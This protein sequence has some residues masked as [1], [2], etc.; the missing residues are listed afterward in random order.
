MSASP[1]ANTDAFTSSNRPTR[2]NRVSRRN[3]C[4]W[5][6]ATTYCLQFDNGDS[7]CR[8]VGEPDQWTDKYMGVY[9]HRANDA[10]QP[11]SWSLRT[12]EPSTP[13]IQP[14]DRETC[15]GVYACL[16]ALCPLG[17][18]QRIAFGLTE[19]Q[20]ARYGWLPG[21]VAGQ[22]ALIADLLRTYSREQLRGVPGFREHNRHL[23]IRGAGLMLPTR[24]LDGYIVALDLRRATVKEKQA[25]YFKLSSRTEDDADAPSPGA[26]AHL[27]VPT[28]GVTVG[29]VIGLTEGIKKADAAADALGYPV[30]S[31]PGIDARRDVPTFL[32]RLARN[33]V[34]LML[35]QDD[36][37]KKGGDVVAAVTRARQ[38]VAATAIAHG[39]A[40]RVAT[41]D[42]TVAKG[43]DDL[44]AAG[45]TFALER[46]CPATDEPAA[47]VETPAITPAIVPLFAVMA[48]TLRIQREALQRAGV[49][50][51]GLTRGYESLHRFVLTE[52]FTESEKKMLL[53][54]LRDKFGYTFG[55]PVLPAFATVRITDAEKPRAGLSGNSF[56]TARKRFVTDGLLIASQRPALDGSPTGRSFDV[57]TVNGERL[58]RLIDDL[59]ADPGGQTEE[60][61]ARAVVRA[62][63]ARARHA[64]M[65]KE[66]ER[67]EEQ[68]RITRQQLAS[69]GAQRRHF[70]EVTEQLSHQLTEKEAEAD[71]MRRAAEDAQREAQRIINQS[72]RDSIACRGCGTL[73]PLEDWRCDDCRA[74][75]TSADR[76]DAKDLSP[77]FVGI[78]NGERSHLPITSPSDG[79]LIPTKLGDK[80]S[81]EAKG[82][83]SVGRDVDVKPCRG[84][85]G[86]L[87]PHGWE[88]KRCRAPLNIATASSLP[89]GV[90][91]GL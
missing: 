43:I 7:G 15:D 62:E 44:L 20:A 78:G 87:T 23:I 77:S 49:T 32:E 35:D 2:A 58:T 10:T 76:F 81:P 89:Q 74:E 91:H 61:Q 1:H 68:D 14:A 55:L 70:A 60:R 88:C 80:S 22:A 47:T 46:Y 79:L 19:A 34:V 54:T 82:E 52:S 72:Q 73:I 53:W 6:N 17:E 16:L 11:R 21:D 48:K 67:R 38:A 40:V 26:P 45:H 24:D 41:W 12:P 83:G 86:T 42:H 71:A 37:A 75:N 56:D 69:I 30:I 4:R 90:S 85:C 29:D 13:A 36:P 84:G 39:Y 63:E 3:P 28:G 8:T 18:N 51:D 33:V 9:L 59:T 25:R 31:I 50:I 65:L 27:A 64:A 57:F 5:C 66:R